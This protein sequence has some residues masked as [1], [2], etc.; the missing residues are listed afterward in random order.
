MLRGVSG[1]SVF[2]SRGSVFISSAI[3]NKPLFNGKVLVI[4]SFQISTHCKKWPS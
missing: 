3:S 4:H 1:F 2:T